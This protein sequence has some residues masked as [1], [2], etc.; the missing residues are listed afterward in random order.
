MSPQSI[1]G[2]GIKVWIERAE[3]DEINLDLGASESCKWMCVAGLWMASSEVK[4]ED[5]DMESPFKYYLK[6]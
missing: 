2:E 3:S 1:T 6:S 5:T 4:A